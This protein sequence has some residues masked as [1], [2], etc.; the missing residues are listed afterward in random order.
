VTTQR[1]S[2]TMKAY[3]DVIVEHWLQAL[4]RESESGS[5]P[6]ADSEC[7]EHLSQ[8]LDIA[9]T[10][11]EGKEFSADDRN[12]YLRYGAIRYQQSYTIPLL[13]REAKLLQ[14]SIADFM[15]H[16]FAATE[17]IHLVPDTLRLM[18]TIETLWKAAGKSETE[19][20][21]VGGSIRIPASLTSTLALSRSAVIPLLGRAFTDFGGLRQ[22]WTACKLF[23]Y[24]ICGF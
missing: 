16:N 10:V 2:Q 1:L 18:G 22:P 17:M 13:M 23:N 14:A 3:R 20:T 4:K 12:A 21:G 24:R 6:V 5:S 11:A 15:Q 19:K 8:L 7:R 9:A